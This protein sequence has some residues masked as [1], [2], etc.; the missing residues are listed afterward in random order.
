[1][2]STEFGTKQ[3]LDLKMKRLIIP[4]LILAVLVGCSSGVRVTRSIRIKP[5]GVELDGSYLAD[6]SLR[7]LLR[8]DLVRY[9]PFRVILIAT[10]ECQFRRMEQTLDILASANIFDVRL[11]IAESPNGEVQFIPSTVDSEHVP[12]H[13]VS[14]FISG[15]NISARTNSE[16]VIKS[17]VGS[18]DATCISFN[19]TPETSAQQLFGHLLAW[20][21][22][23]AFIMRDKE[24]ISNQFIERIR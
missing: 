17:G 3:L 21:S 11:S 9:G 1:M 23:G 20:Q 15:N 5:Q 4:F 24:I 8:K 10:A 16:E 19:A 7:D 22:R 18:T 12:W 6:M 14:A 2:C 13:K